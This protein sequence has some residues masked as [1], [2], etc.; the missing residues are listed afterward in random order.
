MVCPTIVVVV[1]IILP[2]NVLLSFLS[3]QMASLFSGFSGFSGFSDER[4]WAY[5]GNTVVAVPRNDSWAEKVRGGLTIDQLIT[6]EDCVAPPTV[7]LLQDVKTPIGSK[8]IMDYTDSDSDDIIVGLRIKKR[9]P[10]K[11]K[12]VSKWATK[13][14]RPIKETPLG[15]ENVVELRTACRLCAAP[16]DTGLPVCN[17]DTLC[18]AYDSTGCAHCGYTYENPFGMCGK[19]SDPTAIR[20]PCYSIPIQ[21]PCAK[22]HPAFVAKMQAL[23]KRDMADVEDDEERYYRRSWH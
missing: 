20:L 10:K 17:C 15:E 22:C 11:P 14:N 8:I 21:Q 6:A 7:V 9:T 23:H 16:Y 4:A 13:M 18:A 5:S 1:A 12:R 3:F 2:T 19:R